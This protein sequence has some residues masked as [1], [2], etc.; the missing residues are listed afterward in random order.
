MRGP[1]WQL[2]ALFLRGTLQW[3]RYDPEPCATSR[4]PLAVF[5]VV[6]SRGTLSGFEAVGDP[7]AAEMEMPWEQIPTAPGPSIIAD[8]E[9][10]GRKQGQGS[11]IHR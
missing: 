10:R 7:K 9:G 1:Y 3:I 2:L 8:S 6:E 5:V 11:G 4:G